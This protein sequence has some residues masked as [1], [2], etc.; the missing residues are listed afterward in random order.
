MFYKIV[1]VSTATKTGETYVLVHFWEQAPRRNEPPVLVNDFIMTLREDVVATL[2]KNIA[3]YW[4][5]AQAHGWRGDHS[6]AEAVTSGDFWEGEKL[7]RRK[8]APLPGVTVRDGGD[9]HGILR[10]P[11]VQQLRGKTVEGWLH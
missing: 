1:E 3:N 11:D 4:T 5:R 9:P 8:G 2:R 7:M 10:R 6:S